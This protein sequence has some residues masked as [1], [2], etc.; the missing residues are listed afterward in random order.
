MIMMVTVLYFILEGSTF[1]SEL[2][3]LVIMM[4]GVYFLTRTQGGDRTKFIGLSIL[5]LCGVIFTHHLTPF[6][7][8]LFFIVCLATNR[9]LRPLSGN[10][11]PPLGKPTLAISGIFTLITFVAILSYWIFVSK[12]PL[13]SLVGISRTLLYG[14]P[15]T[16]LAELAYVLSPQDI[17]TVRG[18]IKFSSHYIFHAMFAIILLRGL[19]V[20]DRERPP[21]FYSFTLFLFAAGVWS[22]IQL[23]AL[24]LG[25]PGVM[26]VE[27]LIMLGWIWGF[28]PLAFCI[29]E[30]KRRWGKQLG[31]VLLASFMLSNIYM[32]P[33]MNWDLQTPGRAEGQC[34]LREDYALAETIDFTGGTATSWKFNRVAIYDVQ[35]SWPVPLD[36]IDVSR[37]EPDGVDAVDWVII[38]KK[39]LESY[40]GGYHRFMEVGRLS[41]FKIDV[42]IT[43][44]ELLTE[45][46]SGGRDRIY[47]SNNLAVFK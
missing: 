38:K 10:W 40:I 24:P 17:L 27:R 33:P 14:T 32:L 41:R 20:R 31:I 34:V 45:D 12:G 6:L 26:T 8:L 11:V 18:A 29:L 4:A 13:E 35:I 28:A 44:K 43:L 7:L 46:S 5:C 42:L 16:T 1:K 9:I 22:L 15:G 30:S 25:T 36:K 2:F 39:E 47:D 37:I 21:E 3:A 23:Y 19:L